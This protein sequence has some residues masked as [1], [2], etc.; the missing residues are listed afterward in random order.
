VLVRRLEREGF[1]PIIFGMLIPPNG[2]LD[3]PARDARGGK[4]IGEI[5]QRVDV[6]APRKY[7]TI[8]HAG[9]V[10][11]RKGLVDEFNEHLH[12]DRLPLVPK[13]FQTDEE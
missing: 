2:T 7:A 12:L 8:R 5:V 11:E 3:L 1:E 13:L 6:I 10:V 9:E 4:L